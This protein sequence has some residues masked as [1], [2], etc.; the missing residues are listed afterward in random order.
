[1]G[2][3]IEPVVGYLFSIGEDKHFKVTDIIKGDIVS[4]LTVGNSVL[5]TMIVEK[6]TKRVFIGNKEGAV[7]LYDINPVK[8]SLIHY[9][10]KYSVHQD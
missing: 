5:T 1:M 7:Y 3:C 8:I 2:L 10:I 9:K 4:D 6:E